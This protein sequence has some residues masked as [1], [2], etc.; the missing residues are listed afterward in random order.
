MR[1]IVSENP[2]N[3]QIEETLRNLTEKHSINITDVHYLPSQYLSRH[4]HEIKK[5][6]EKSYTHTRSN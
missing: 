1:L 4:K 2:S 6:I 3:L 5:I